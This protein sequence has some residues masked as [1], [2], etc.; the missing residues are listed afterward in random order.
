MSWPKP[1]VNDHDPMLQPDLAKVLEQHVAAGFPPDLALDLVLNELLVRAADITRASGAALALMR[2]EEMV[3]RASTGLHAPDLGIPLSMQDGLSG[4]C[5]RTRMPQLC[6]DTE[7]DPRV[8]PATA[9]RL[10]VRSM[11]IVPVFAEEAD[12]S[13]VRAEGGPEAG[14]RNLD[15][16]L[17]ILSPVPN[18]FAESAQELLEEFARESASIR[19]AADKLRERVPESAFAS[20]AEFGLKAGPEPEVAIPAEAKPGVPHHQL[21]EVAAVGPDDA[22][23]PS[24]PIALPAA[25][26]TLR[27]PLARQPYEMWTLVMGTLV[28]AAAIGVSFLIGSRV[29]WLGS[30]QPAVGIAPEL[31]SSAATAATTRDANSAGRRGH[32]FQ[33][34]TGTKSGSKSAS[35]AAAVASPDELVVYDKGKVI[36]RIKP[37]PAKPDAD[38]TAS[39]PS[40]AATTGAVSAGPANR[41]AS[42]GSATGDHSAAQ[43]K[44]PIVR[45]SSSTR[46][47]APRTVWLAPSQAESRLLSR[48]EPEYPADALAARRAGDVVLE[49]HVAEDGTVSSV[50]ALS[51]DPLLAP[52]AADAVRNWR[53]QPYR[54]HE[55]PSPFQTDVTLT[56]S[57][58]N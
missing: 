56:F 22:I 9:R 16:V 40:G 43:V 5:V 44:S 52:A 45:A 32:D 25:R 38:L 33:A 46:I 15:G 57:L 34:K 55:Q 6:G 35:G 36:F 51:G 27:V 20:L 26:S 21:A 23:P 4:A 47:A 53:Y 28:I 50:R 24:A 58:P 30:P 7:A 10:G 49:V 17:E 1:S 8:D 12:E 42:N 3:C 14:G 11:L 39:A 13:V 54:S 37:T 2:G 48:V 18:A 29:G 19:R 41:T 31:P